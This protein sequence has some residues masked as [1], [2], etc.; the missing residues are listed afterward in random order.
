[1]NLWSFGPMRIAMPMILFKKAV[2]SRFLFLMASLMFFT[3]GVFLLI[4]LNMVTGF[5]ARFCTFMCC[6]KHTVGCSSL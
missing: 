1:M 4:V 2:H 3:K 5:E 6:R